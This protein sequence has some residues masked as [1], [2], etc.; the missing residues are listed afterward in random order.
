M[1][2]FCRRQPNDPPDDGER[3]TAIDWAEIILL[4]IEVFTFLF[5]IVS[6]L[7]LWYTPIPYILFGLLLVLLLVSFILYFVGSYNYPYRKQWKSFSQTDIALITGGSNGLGLEIA[8]SL[9]VKDV[10]VYVIDKVS[11]PEKLF[12]DSK[13]NFI[14]CDLGDERDL[15][16][17]LS[18]LI[19]DLNAENRYISIL[20]NN[21]GIRDNRSLVNLKFDKVK[22]LFNVN[23][24]AQIFILQKILSNHLSYN[25][26]GKLSL[27][28][29]SSILGTFAPKN[30]SVYS[31]TK[32]AQIMLHESLQQE[33]KQFPKIRLMLVTTGQ[34][35]TELFKDVSAPKQ[36]IAPVVNHVNLAREITE[37]VEKG[38]MG[39]LSR[40]FYANFLP[41][42]R[43]T[44]L[45]VQDFC[46]WF[47]E[48]DEQI[49]ESKD[50]KF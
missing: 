12:K 22:D 46:R 36:F 29:V 44:P 14:Q 6:F 18:T 10:T 30:L 21:A 26:N 8:K 40:P 37:K 38:Y 16:L 48:I 15:K 28:T 19:H 4:I 11:P 24:I 3:N 35:N 34:M 2:R 39:N 5:F 7:T 45:I 17:K 25:V 9:L 41:G 42:V 33:L 13:F 49:K 32:A 43:T 27:V 23:T 20:I 47:S 31:A 1:C 50:F